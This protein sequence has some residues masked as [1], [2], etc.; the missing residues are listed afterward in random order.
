MLLISL[1]VC[2]PCLSA[3]SRAPCTRESRG[4]WHV[5]VPVARISF[6]LL[7]RKQSFCMYDRA[8]TTRRPVPCER[9]TD[10]TL[11]CKRCLVFGRNSVRQGESI[12]V[13][14]YP[15][16]SSQS[17]RQVLGFCTTSKLPKNCKNPTNYVPKCVWCCATVRVCI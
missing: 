5:Y 11:T 8:R 16:F 13:T 12:V 4:T 1:Y 14:I 17:Q 3:D 15:V 6:I 10:N 2:T 9:D 7:H